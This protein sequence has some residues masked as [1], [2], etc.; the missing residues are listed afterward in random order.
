MRV[1]IFDY[2]SNYSLVLPEGV[3]GVQQALQEAMDMRGI[4][5]KIAGHIYRIARNKGCGGVQVRPERLL[6]FGSGC[7]MLPAYAAE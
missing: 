2:D 3:F 6:V 1:G 4:S 7:I 5:V